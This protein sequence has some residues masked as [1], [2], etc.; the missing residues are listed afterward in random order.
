MKTIVDRAELLRALT[1]MHLQNVVERRNTIPILSN[2]RMEAFE[3]QLRLTATDMDI[4]VVQLVPVTME[5]PGAT[6]V[7]AHLFYEGCQKLSE[8]AHVMLDGTQVENRMLLDCG[9]THYEFPTLPSGDF[10]VMSAQDFSHSFTLPVAELRRLIDKVRFATGTE[11]ARHYLN[12]IYFHVV[13]ADGSDVLRAVATDGHRLARADAEPPDGAADMPGIIV[14]RK[15]VTVLRRML[16][17]ADEDI[18]VEASESRVRFSLGTV[19]MTSKLVD[20][21]YPDYQRVIPQSNDK[22]IDVETSGFT[23]AVGRMTMVTAGDSSN[24]VKLAVNGSRM[25]VSA[26][27]QDGAS[28]QEELEVSYAGPALAIGFN[29][30]YVMEMSQNFDGERT[31]F[32]VGD[33]AKAVVFNDPHDERLLYVLMPVRV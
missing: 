31:S 20:G 18:R 22:V 19:V 5:A 3:G 13:D 6:S 15:T 12:G 24:P 2:L 21:T 30:R 4:E 27:G 23:K 10:P 25:E 29:A 33:P 14:S 1:H 32:R 11:E 26:V 28:G 16:D 9:P 8:G 7:P 17:D